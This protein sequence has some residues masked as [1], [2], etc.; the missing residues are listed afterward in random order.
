MK[1]KRLLISILFIFLFPSFS[2]GE[3]VLYD[4]AEYWI[5]TSE[6]LTIGWDDGNPSEVGIQYFKGQMKNVETNRIYTFDVISPALTKTLKLPKTGHY[7]FLVQA[8]KKELGI[9]YCS[10]WASSM[11]ATNNPTVNGVVRVW[12]F[13]GFVN[14]PGSIVIK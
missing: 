3:I 10:D 8:C 6:F 1:K 2:V 12:R 4:C 13:F 7:I 9:E 14:P 11:D 5:P